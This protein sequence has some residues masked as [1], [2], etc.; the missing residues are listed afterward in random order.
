MKALEINLNNLNRMLFI[1]EMNGYCIAN[2][3]PF[4]NGRAEKNLNELFNADY[5]YNPI[6]PNLTYDVI[7]ETNYWETSFVGI[8]INSAD[9]LR[10]CFICGN[11]FWHF[12]FHKNQYNIYFWRE[13][14]I[15]LVNKKIDAKAILAYLFEINRKQ[16]SNKNTF[17]VWPAGVNILGPSRYEEMSSCYWVT[18]EEDTL[19]IIENIFNKP[20]EKLG[21][22]NLF[23]FDADDIRW[24]IV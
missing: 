19:K 7:T 3:D 6:V 15:E 2:P 13:Q 11:G 12:F 14:L 5:F 24:I 23:S 22:Y 18:G 10:A 9:N 21:N 16:I 8:N 4:I 1:N 20:T 17:Q